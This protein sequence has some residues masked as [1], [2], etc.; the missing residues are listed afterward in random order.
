MNG[1]FEIGA[2]VRRFTWAVLMVLVFGLL[3]ACDSSE[4]RAEKHFESAMALLEAGD[5]DRAIVEFKNVFKLNGKHHEARSAF[6]ALQRKRGNIGGALRQYIRLVEQYP[7]DMD[8]NRA[9][10][11]MNAQIGN[12]VDMDRYLTKAL[13]LDPNDQI[14]KALQIVFNYRN[15]IEDRDVSTANLAAD[16]AAE[17]RQDLP[18]YIMLWQVSI[19]NKVRNSDFSGALADVDNAIAV[20]PDDQ[21]LYSARLSILQALGDSFEIVEQLKEMIIHFPEDDAARITLVQWYL[22]QGQLDDAEAFLRSDIDQDSDDPAARMTLLRF[23]TD[24]RGNEIALAELNNMI[25]EGTTA[26]IFK[27]LKAGLEF[28]LGEREKAIGEM[29]TLIA[30]LEPS[31]ETRAIKYGLSQMLLQT[32]NVVG[33]RALT[34]EILSE[35]PSHAE[36]LK[37]KASWLIDGDDAGAAIIALR[38]ALEQ[39]PRDPDIM[40]MMARAH[41]REGNR[42][43]V[44]EML[45]LAVESSNKA[46]EESIRYSQYLRNAENYGAAERVLVEALRLLPENPGI[47]SELGEVYLAD[48]D[49]PRAQQVIDTLR[50]MELPQ[51]QGIA[52]QL[53][54]QL[55]QAQDNNSAAVAFLEG[56]VADGDAGFEAHIAI[57]RTYL[58]EGETEKA[59]LYV[60]K[61]IAD[62]PENLGVQFMDAAVNAAMGNTVEAESIYRAMIEKDDGQVQVWIAL[63]RLLSAQDKS[64]QAATV[65]D[66]AQT[67][68]P[69]DGTLKWIKAGLLEREGDIDA[70]IKIYEDLYAQ[71]SNNLI[72]ANNLASLMTGTGS[73]AETIDRAYKIA[74]RLR[75]SPV[76]PYQDTYGWIA[77]LRGNFAEAVEAL[78]PAAA[79]MGSEPLVQYHLAQAYVSVENFDDAIV[80]FR[81]VIELTGAADSRDFVKTSRSEITRLLDLQKSD[82]G[83]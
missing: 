13:E 39:S 27:S 10:A 58:G 69:A 61:L 44:G 66:H 22:S 50:R 51:A 57:V 43:L 45:S 24:L 12:W 83:D 38:T 33:A 26:P 59:R 48:K 19:D 5:E 2:F 8:A 62:D 56:L 53:N 35:D 64:D 16:A 18:D 23:M 6:A 46:P 49:W 77:Y 28:E 42:E 30:E 14:S 34:E 73:D 72:V 68:L 1:F 76:A 78:E 37:L 52:N 65:I 54:A 32:G 31:D 41:E 55:L 67:A 81:K 7:D 29:E 21:S 70:A 17:M 80:Q 25:A 3:S 63:F 20:S 9:L 47:L 40:T 74:R 60:D 79:G 36:S 82:S 71:D 15:A 75:Q 11:E 4:E